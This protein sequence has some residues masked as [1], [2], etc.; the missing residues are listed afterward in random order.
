[1]DAPINFWHDSPSLARISQPRLCVMHI[2]LVLILGG[3]SN[4]GFGGRSS[5]LPGI[6]P[7]SLPSPAFILKSHTPIILLTE[8]ASH[9][10]L[11][12]AN[13]LFALVLLS[14]ASRRCLLP[15]AGR[16]PRSGASLFWRLLPLGIIHTTFPPNGILMVAGTPIL[17]L[18]I[19][20]FAVVSFLVPR[21]NH[22]C[23]RY[24]PREQH[25]FVVNDCVRLVLHA[26]HPCS[27]HSLCFPHVLR[28]SVRSSVSF[29]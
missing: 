20:C 26:H 8:S 11:Q 10:L 16:S 5:A 17:D 24:P 23:V 2:R 6:M 19:R 18:L 3:S 25:M 22:S 14:L 13:E 4:G 12:K 21:D 15:F 28:S 9:H 1:M 7:P 27:C 29:P